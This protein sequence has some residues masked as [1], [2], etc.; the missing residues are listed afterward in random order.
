MIKDYDNDASWQDEILDELRQNRVGMIEEASDNSI[1][2]AIVDTSLNA[3][4]AFASKVFYALGVCPEDVWITH[5]AALLICNADPD[6]KA[7]GK[8]ATMSMRRAMKVI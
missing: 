3:I 4:S 5:S 7:E 1:F 2:G 8:V 6:V